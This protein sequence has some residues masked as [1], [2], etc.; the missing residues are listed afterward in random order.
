LRLRPLATAPEEDRDQ[1]LERIN[2]KLEHIGTDEA[3]L[4]GVTPEDIG[5]FLR[6]GGA[7]ADDENH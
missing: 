3:A 7:R 6:R 5:E 4:Y 2:A 1:L